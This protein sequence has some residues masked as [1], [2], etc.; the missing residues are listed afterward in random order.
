MLLLKLEARG[1]SLGRM[2][3]ESERVT[4]RDFCIKE[5]KVVILVIGLSSSSLPRP[6]ERRCGQKHF[7][8]AASPR[9]SIV[10]SSLAQH[11]PWAMA[12][13]HMYRWQVGTHARTE[14][15][16]IHALGKVKASHPRSSWSYNC[17]STAD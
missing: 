9:S 5:V 14:Y 2:R 10:Q 1:P 7:L 15:K 4:Y 8:G 3:R 16:H 6:L 12:H 17:L 13:A 11:S